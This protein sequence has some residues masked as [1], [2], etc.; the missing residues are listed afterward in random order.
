MTAASALEFFNSIKSKL[1]QRH[2]QKEA[3]RET[4]STAATI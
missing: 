3:A 2:L 4:N 1:D